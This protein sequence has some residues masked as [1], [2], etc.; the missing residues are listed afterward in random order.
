MILLLFRTVYLGQEIH[1]KCLTMAVL[2]TF[3][4][5]IETESHVYVTFCYLCLHLPCPLLRYV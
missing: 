4:R 2:V 1:S 5:A 3:T